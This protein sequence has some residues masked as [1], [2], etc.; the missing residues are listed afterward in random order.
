MSDDP[1]GEW[2]TDEMSE[3]DCCVEFFC[4]APGATFYWHEGALFCLCQVCGYHGGLNGERAMA[5]GPM[6]GGTRYRWWTLPTWPE[7]ARLDAM[8]AGRWR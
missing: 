3:A 1:Y 2:Y 8:R 6:V 4:R 5:L 7:L